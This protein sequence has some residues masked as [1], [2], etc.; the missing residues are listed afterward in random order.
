VTIWDEPRYRVLAGDLECE[1]CGYGI[2]CEA[3]PERCPMCQSENPWIDRPWRP[4]T[5]DRWRS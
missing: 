4:F 3:P 1:V 2:A 5:R